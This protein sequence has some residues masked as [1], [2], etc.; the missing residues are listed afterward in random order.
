MDAKLR[1]GLAHL[2]DVPLL[3]EAT[4]RCEHL[5]V[6]ELLALDTGSV[7]RTDR[8]AG[9]SVDISVAGRMVSQGELIVIENTLAARLSDFCER[10]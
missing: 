3:L 8:A 6:S 9:E 1:D 5:T 10:I 2:S 4:I 7:I